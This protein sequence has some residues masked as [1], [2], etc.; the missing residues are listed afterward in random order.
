MSNDT[1]TREHAEAEVCKLA[2]AV[3]EEPASLHAVSHARRVF[4][5][6]QAERLGRPLNKEGE[7]G[8]EG[9]E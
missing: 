8:S 1:L 5:G 4:L 7:R 9:R 6:D 3:V 2:A